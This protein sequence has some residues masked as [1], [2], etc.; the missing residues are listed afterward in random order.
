MCIKPFAWEM[1]SGFCQWLVRS[2]IDCAHASGGVQMLCRPG[3]YSLLNSEACTACAAGRFG[4]AAAATTSACSGLCSAGQY[5]LAAAVTCT[6]CPAG[7]FGQSV[8]LSSPTCTGTC[9]QGYACPA[10]ST[11]ATALICPAGLYSYA[12][13]AVCAEC[14]PGTFG[15]SPGL[16][17]A[18]C[19]GA[20]TAGYACPAGSTNTTASA[21][22]AGQYSFAGAGS[23]T[24]CAAGSWSA[25]TVRSTVCDN[26]CTAGYACPAGSTNA[27]TL[28]CPA[29]Q[30]SL[31]G[32]GSC[33]NCSAGKWSTDVARS[34][35]CVWN[36]TAG[37]VCPAG[38]S[39]STT[40][41]CPNGNCP[42]FRELR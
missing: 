25:S 26:M 14:P 35:P 23:C 33:T 19:S 36:C 42:W 37:F 32:A 38:S 7:A 21:C 1:F 5:S 34:I 29:G 30:F 3:Q 11:N 24:G 15:D 39:N 8:G 16:S 27:T 22:S 20:C 2:C 6:L 4:S 12:G 17:S 40:S 18:L 41:E 31:A 10:G 13:A 9:V 28:A